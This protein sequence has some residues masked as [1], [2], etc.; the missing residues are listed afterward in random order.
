MSEKVA[1]TEQVHALKMFS[2]FG[3]EKLVVKKV[4]NFDIN[5]NYVNDGRIL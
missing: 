5:K 2:C 3:S 1:L 4:V